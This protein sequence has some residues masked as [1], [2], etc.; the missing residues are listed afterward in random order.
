MDSGRFKRESKDF[1]HFAL[2]I[3]PAIDADEH[4]CDSQYLMGRICRFCRDL[5][6]TTVIQPAHSNESNLIERLTNTPNVLGADNLKSE[7]A[8]HPDLNDD[9]E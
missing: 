8:I 5:Q 2:E 3:S 1:V 6:L 4:Y 7:Y 9:E